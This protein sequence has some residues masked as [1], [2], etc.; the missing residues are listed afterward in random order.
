M[1]EDNNNYIE[2]YMQIT[3]NYIEVYMHEDNK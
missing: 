2:V 3:N 1:H